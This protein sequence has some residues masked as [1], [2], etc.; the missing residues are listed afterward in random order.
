MG[1]IQVFTWYSQRWVP[2][3]GYNDLWQ[4]QRFRMFPPIKWFLSFMK[5]LFLSKMEYKAGLSWGQQDL[6]QSAPFGDCL[7]VRRFYH[8]FYYR[9]LPGFLG[10]SRTCTPKIDSW[11]SWQQLIPRAL[12]CQWN[13]SRWAPINVQWLSPSNWSFSVSTKQSVF[14]GLEITNHLPPGSPG[15]IRHGVLENQP[16]SWNIPWLS[17]NISIILWP[18]SPALPGL[19]DCPQAL[20]S[21]ECGRSMLCGLPL[22]TS[23]QDG[24]LGTWF[25]Y[26]SHDTRGALM[27]WWGWLNKKML[28][29]L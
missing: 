9:D 27:K 17:I 14:G 7:R 1:N 8:G 2:S 11:E 24:C 3:N 12:P 18:M 13:D 10:I 21:G 25:E 29:D 4:Q 16:F 20:Q 28:W 22:S 6:S 15:V 26:P 23:Q 5:W 19:K